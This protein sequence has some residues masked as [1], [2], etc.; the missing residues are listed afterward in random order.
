MNLCLIINLFIMQLNTVY[1]N[2]TNIMGDFKRL[3]YNLLLYVHLYLLVSIHVILILI[4]DI[5]YFIQDIPPIHFLYFVNNITC[6]LYMQIQFFSFVFL[7]IILSIFLIMLFCTIYHFYTILVFM[8]SCQNNSIL[9]CTI[10]SKLQYDCIAYWLVIFS[11]CHFI[12]HTKF[13][14][15]FGSVYEQT[16]DTTNYLLC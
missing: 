10:Q 14:C 9:H 4:C 7:F 8:L 11:S 5:W 6:L 3:N 12:I 1:T 16:I 13:K 2:L 15:L